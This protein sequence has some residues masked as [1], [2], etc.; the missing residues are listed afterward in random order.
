MYC[1]VFE[2][3]LLQINST[4]SDLSSSLACYESGLGNAV[5]ASNVHIH[6]VGDGKVGKSVMVK[7]LLEMFHN[8]VVDGGLNGSG[9]RVYLHPEHSKTR[10]IKS[11]NVLKEN[12]KGKLIKTM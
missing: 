3:L 12:E 2:V 7:W 9:E 1:C 10:G 5:D 4:I 11:W 8:N 6:V